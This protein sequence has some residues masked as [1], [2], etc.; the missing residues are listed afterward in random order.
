[1]LLLSDLFKEKQLKD[2]SSTTFCE[3]YLLYFDE[4]KGHMPLLAYP[5]NTLMYNEQSM[6]PINIHSIW[7]LDFEEQELL[8]H[9]D[10]EYGDK[11]Y[12]A[13]KFLVKSERKKQRAGLNE[14]TPET[15][16]I[17]VAL[18]TELELFGGPIIKK[19]TKLIK[20]NYSDILWEI[21]DGENARRAVI[22]TEKVLDKIKKSE[23]YKKRINLDIKSTILKY[24][25]R[26][27]DEG[28]SDSIKMQKAMSYL[29]LRGFDVSSIKG[30]NGSAFDNV[31]FFQKSV[32]SNEC[33]GPF[34][35]T[36]INISKNSQELEVLIQNCTPD[37]IKHIEVSIT[38]VREFFEKEILRE[39][40][41]TWYAQEE[42]IFVAPLFPLITNYILTILNLDNK[43]KILVK[44]IDTLKL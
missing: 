27:I 43:Q 31:S 5:D 3:I 33:I 42:L 11:I 16:V 23:E 6:R 13:K 2:L 40:I 4:R 9:V 10:L 36:E 25:Q 35:V 34:N 28:K 24:F 22:K 41:E 7:F 18:N 20:N 30:F 14:E 29:L 15:I 21:I 39:K 19:L 17:I 44:M 26:I 37:D 12:F 1:M 38:H 32:D 8:D